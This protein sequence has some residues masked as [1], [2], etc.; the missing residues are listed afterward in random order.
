[1]PLSLAWVCQHLLLGRRQ[2]AVDAPQHGE[3]QDDVLVLA[4]LEGV[5]DQVRDAQRKLTISLWLFINH[6]FGRPE[7]G[8]EDKLHQRGIWKT[9]TLYHSRAKQATPR[10]IRGQRIRVNASVMEQT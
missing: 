9:A 8:S 3:R 10:T 5:A 6:P 4:A 1:M 7:C 2:H